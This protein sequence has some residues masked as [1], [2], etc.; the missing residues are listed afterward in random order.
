MGNFALPNKVRSIRLQETTRVNRKVMMSYAYQLCC[1]SNGVI[2]C[3]YGNDIRLYL[4]KD[5]GC[6]EKD[7]ARPGCW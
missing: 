6:Y 1:D 4:N 5:G 2:C 3:N 7:R